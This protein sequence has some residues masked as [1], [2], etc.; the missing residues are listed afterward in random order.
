MKRMLAIALAFTAMASV[1]TAQEMERQAGDITVR[2]QTLPRVERTTIKA[3]DF[4]ASVAE[5]EEVDF[6]WNSIIF[7]RYGD[8]GDTNRRDLTVP[9]QFDGT[10]VT[11]MRGFGQIFAPRYLYSIYNQSV[12]NENTSYVSRVDTRFES[13]QQYIDQFKGARNFTLQAVIFPFYHNP[14]NNPSNPGLVSFLKTNFNFGGTSYRNNGFGSGRRALTVAR[15]IPF[16]QDAL[17]TTTYQ[18]DFGDTLI[19]YTVIE[20][21]GQEG[22]DDAPIEFAQNESLVLLY[23]NEFAPGVTQP[24]PANDGREWQRAVASDEFGGGDFEE[25]PANPGEFLDHRTNPLDTAKVFGVVMYRV[26]EA[27]SI[28]SAWRALRFGEKS[29]LV[30]LNTS[31]FGVVVLSSGVKYH[32]GRDASSQGIG[33]VTP[34][35]VREYATIPFSLTERSDVR[36]AMY[37]M[38]GQLVRSLVDANYIRGEYSVDLNTEGLANGAYVLRMTV[39]DKAYTQKLN[40]SR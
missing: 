10:P 37:D 35:P 38:S 20:F 2:P 19:K 39:G 1:A 13:D 4:S 7:R 33:A 36:L 28:Y 8:D 12:Y 29:A 25:D 16:D 22:D 24:I 17:D 27:D 6:I 3:P 14:R 26:N 30:N 34:N 5:D 32:F 40:I 18:N 31:F 23:T 11:V 15:E 9:L 21:T